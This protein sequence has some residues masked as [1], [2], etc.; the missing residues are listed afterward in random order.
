MYTR[1]SPEVYNNWEAEGNVGWNYTDVLK[2]FKKAEN[3]SQPK[4]EIEVEYHGFSGPLKVN[5]YPYK[6]YMVP[7]LLNSAKQL[8]YQVIDVNGHSQ[9]GFTIAS[10]MIDHGVRD[11]PSRA[12]LRPVLRN[13][14]LR[15]VLETH[16]EKVLFNMN[17]TR[18]VGVQFTNKNGKSTTVY[19]NKEVILSAGVV[20][21][22]QILQLSGVGPKDLLKSLQIRVV[23]DLPVGD[24]NLHY[25]FGV[26]SLVKLKNV[27]YEN[28]FST[29]ALKNYLAT[30]TGPFSSTGT[31]QVTAFLE[32]SIATKGV[33]N[34]Q[35]FF[36]SPS[37]RCSQFKSSKTNDNTT[38][39]AFRPIFLLTNCRGYLKIK[40]RNPFEYP[41]IDPQYLCN[42][43]EVD[44][45]VEAMGILQNLTRTPLFKKYLVQ[46]DADTNS[47]CA[48]YY[49]GS[50]NYWRCVAKYYTLS[51]NHHAGTAKMGPAGDPLAVVDPQ[52][53]VHGIPNLRVIDAS[54]MPSP[55]NA[56]PIGPIIMIGEKGADMILK[57]YQ[58]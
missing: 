5:Q 22:A 19:A 11:S 16:V 20:G 36:D 15:V 48:N 24:G 37:D 32:T 56:N 45:L 55:V 35:V 43:T 53:R 2:Y 28:V 1:G 23:K 58:P 54:I 27:P 39:M 34:I 25:H 44:A 51:E 50:P 38:T 40:S 30:Q 18:A 21:S 29:D 52:L 49:R 3:N 13:P 9:T 14:Y 12:Y 6:P 41:A 7:I 47:A 57:T 42:S 31:T 10:I 4:N 17:G 46:F 8:G 26:P 33:P